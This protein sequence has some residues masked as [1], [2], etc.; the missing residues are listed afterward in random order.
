VA[1]S[2]QVDRDKALTGLKYFDTHGR[3][4]VRYPMFQVFTIFLQKLALRNNSQTAI[5]D[6]VHRAVYYKTV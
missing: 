5:A 6:V 1:N 4:I 3:G 2:I